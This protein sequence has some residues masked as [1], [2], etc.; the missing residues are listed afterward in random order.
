MQRICK[1]WIIPS[2]RKFTDKDC[3][4]FICLSWLLGTCLFSLPGNHRVAGTSDN[5]LLM[6]GRFGEESECSVETWPRSFE[7]FCWTIYMGLSKNKLPKNPIVFSSFKTIWVG[8]IPRFQTY[9]GKRACGS[10]RSRRSRC[11]IPDF[12]P[13]QVLLECWPHLKPRFCAVPKDR[14]C[15]ITKLQGP[16]VPKQL[17]YIYIYK[18]WSPTRMPKYLSGS[19][20]YINRIFLLQNKI[21]KD[22]PKST[23]KSGTVAV[24]GSWLSHPASGLR[25]SLQFGRICWSR[26]SK[27]V[28]GL[29]RSYPAEWNPGRDC[30]WQQNLNPKSQD[31][32]S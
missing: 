28:V 3:T 10:R 20:R 8:G 26:W 23:E 18:G 16:V 19:V 1:S 2:S 24:P 6:R 4:V 13:D 21:F 15:S 14:N 12:E 5:C 32:Q 11:T 9:R 7:C 29:L 27:R 31:R 25:S 22:S 17:K 30:R